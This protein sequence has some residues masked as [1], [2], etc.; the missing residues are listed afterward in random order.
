VIVLETSAIYAL[1]DAGDRRHRVARDWYAQ[2]DDDL[3][4][5]DARP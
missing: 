4:P 1:L 5:L 2:L 3:V